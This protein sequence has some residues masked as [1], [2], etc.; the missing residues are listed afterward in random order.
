MARIDIAPLTQWITRFATEHGGDLPLHL[1]QRLQISRRRAGLVLRKLVA[2]GW[3]EALGTPRRPLYKPGA[4]RQVIGR[5]EL[6]G[7]Q[8]DLPWRTDFAPCLDLPLEVARMAEHAFTELLNNA[9]DHS[10]GRNVTVSVRQTP[11]QFQLLVSDDGCGLFQRIAQS[12]DIPDPQLAMLALSKGKLTSDPQRHCGHGL[13]FSSRLA[14][15]V[16]IHANAAAFQSRAWERRAWRAGKPGPV[17]SRA[18]TSIY[19]AIM[20][21][22]PRTLDSV[23]REHSSSGAGYDFARTSVPLQLLAGGAATAMLSSRAQARR[24]AA[25]LKP[26][27]HAEFDFSGIAHVGHGF[28]DELFRVFRREHPALELMA[29]GMGAQ[30][31]AMVDSVRQPTG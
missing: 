22:T 28:A 2:L 7:L 15:V 3:L 30:V 23:L 20:L 8:E 17:S 6:D 31:A 26:F 19:L 14:D 27:T 18:G 12:F 11:L 13:F 1:M 25:G 5:Y 24:A 16:D 10:G 29:V 4:L 21:D 9:I